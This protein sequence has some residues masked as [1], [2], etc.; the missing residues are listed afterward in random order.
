MINMTSHRI[1]LFGYD[2]PH[3][4]TCDFMIAMK[5]WE[6]N[7]VC[8]LAAPWRKL[9]ISPSKIRVSVKRQHR[10]HPAE[11]AK[12]LGI[13]Y[14]SVKHGSKRLRN[15]VKEHRANLGIIGGARILKQK[16]ISAFDHGIV[17]FHPGLI[18]ENRGLDNLK[19]AIYFDLP[20]ALTSH[21]INTRIDAG[22]TI[23]T[24]QIPVF[25][26]DTLFDLTQ[27]LSDAQLSTLK[28]TLKK[29]EGKTWRDFPHAQTSP[30]SRSSISPEKE[31]VF[32]TQVSAYIEKWS[33][34]IEK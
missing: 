32:L 3:T 23:E 24:N 20:Q 26:D 2:F 12:L 15:I 13:P 8:V 7:V 21:F 5:A 4:K 17:N 18:P 1:A 34:V 16:T 22:H 10:F 9:N 6:Y 25:M 28:S 27:R 33:L 19:W 11:I 29:I 30:E 31:E 14:Y